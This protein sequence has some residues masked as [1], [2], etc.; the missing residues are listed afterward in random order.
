M[1]VSIAEAKKD[2]SSVARQAQKEPVVVTRRGE[3]D[4]V[5]LSFAEY[6]QLRRLRAYLNMLRLST[7]LQGVGITASELHEASRHDL[8]VARDLAGLL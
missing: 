1:K 7:E 5:I 2:F 6:K 4:V 3:P 8:E